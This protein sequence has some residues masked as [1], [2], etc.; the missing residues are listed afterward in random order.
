[1]RKT[2]KRRS[3]DWVPRLLLG[4]L[5]L[6]FAFPS[7]AATPLVPLVRVV[8]LSIGESRQVELSDG[9]RTA[10]KL[11]GVEEIRDKVR[12][13]IRSAKARVE[14]DRRPVTLS[15]GNYNLPVAFHGVR[16]DCTITK[17]YL[18]NNRANVEPWGLDKD[19]RVRL[20]P[21]QSP[22]IRPGTFVYPVK[23]KW[24]ASATQMSNEPTFV[25]GGERPSLRSIYYHNGLDIGGAE[26]LVE[27]VAATDGVVVSKGTDVLQG[28]KK[29]TPVN[30]R[31][32]VILSP[33]RPRLVLPIQ[34][35]VLLRR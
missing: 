29:D 30:P 20:W 34:S 3:T 18:A 12:N 24:F 27:V 33:R 13:A 23:Q 1:M 31:Y 17:G 19:A 5:S 10:V 21:A 25:D 22:L 6:L 8:D 2:A 32:D 28:H 7:L 4:V 11:L 35:P 26:A 16:L 15:C 14:I 9:S